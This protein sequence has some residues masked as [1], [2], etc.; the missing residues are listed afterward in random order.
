MADHRDHSAACDNHEFPK[1]PHDLEAERSVLGAVLLNNDYIAIASE[2]VAPEHFFCQEHHH[3][4]Q[5]MLDMR[6][7]RVAID[8][9]TLRDDL[10]RIGDLEASGGAPYLAKL[11]DC[12]PCVS[13]VGFYADIVRQKAILR[14]VIYSTN[15]LQKQVFDGE[16]ASVIIARAMDSLSRIAADNTAPGQNLFDTPEEIENAPPLR[17]AVQ[18]RLVV[19]TARH[20]WS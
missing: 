18:G 17:F 14:R 2:K 9:L 19:E 7:R 13:N 16:D 6:K 5:Q 1:L 15:T 3:I 8:T 12:V 11:V 20:V 4:F 10:E